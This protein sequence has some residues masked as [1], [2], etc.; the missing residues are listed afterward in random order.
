MANNQI[1]V[2]PEGIFQGLSNLDSLNLSGNK[3]SFLDENAVEGGA[4]IFKGLDW[5]AELNL[6]GNQISNLPENIFKSPVRLQKVHLEKNQI[7][8]I[9]DG[10]FEGLLRLKVLW[11][12][13]QTYGKFCP[14]NTPINVQIDHDNTYDD[15]GSYFEET[16]GSYY[17]TDS[18]EE[19]SYDSYSEYGYHYDSNSPGVSFCDPDSAEELETDET[20]S[21]TESES[22]VQNEFKKRDRSCLEEMRERLLEQNTQQVDKPN[23]KRL[24]I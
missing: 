21:E 13:D 2:I 19:K 9:R 10:L 12:G 11:I 1:S 3:I 14:Q 7:S 22:N 23:S 5:L 24:K 15:M 4:N 20:D 6:A 8:S 16:D 17:D 18:E